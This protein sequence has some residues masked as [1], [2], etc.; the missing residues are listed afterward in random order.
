LQAEANF[1]LSQTTTFMDV[2]VTAG[3]WTEL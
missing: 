3:L 1:I 2:P